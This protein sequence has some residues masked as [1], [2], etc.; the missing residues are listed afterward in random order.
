M[1][2]GAESLN[3]PDTFERR[4]E[5]ISPTVSPSSTLRW[6]CSRS[7]DP[8][9]VSRSLRVERSSS[10]TPSWAS[11]SAMRRLTVESGM[12]RR[13]AASEKLFASTTLA[14]IVSELRSVIVSRDLGS[15]IHT[16]IPDSG[17]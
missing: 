16:I 2:G 12:L 14:N 3:T 6:A 15:S 9:S 8:T 13:R 17:K 11:S 5:T 10:R 7:S 4:F 1:L